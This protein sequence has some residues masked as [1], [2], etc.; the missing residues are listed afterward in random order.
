MADPLLLTDTL[1]QNSFVQSIQDVFRTM[2]QHSIV[3]VERAPAIEAPTPEGVPQIIGNVGFV[4]KVNGLVYLCMPEAFGRQ[5]ACAMLGMDVSELMMSG[6]E[7][8]NDVIGE[9][10]NMTVGGFKNSLSDVGF[11]C[12]LTVPTIVRGTGLSVRSI[13]TAHRYIFHFD[14]KGVRVSVDIQMQV[15]TQ[16]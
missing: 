14:C 13:K 2:A 12:K 4:G 9:I 3:F 10:T 1:I 8:L 7:A 16:P 5:V 15:E 6:T 11:P